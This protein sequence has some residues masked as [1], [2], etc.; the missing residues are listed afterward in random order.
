MSP[1]REKNALGGSGQGLP[2]SAFFSGQTEKKAW[3][4]GLGRIPS[5]LSV[6]GTLRAGSRAARHH[7]PQTRS[8]GTF[9][10]T[11]ARPYILMMHQ[12]RQTSGQASGHTSGHTSGPARKKA[13]RVPMRSGGGCGAGFLSENAVLPGAGLG[14]TDFGCL[15]SCAGA[16]PPRGHRGSRRAFCRGWRTGR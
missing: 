7:A 4:S 12:S 6:S 3:L 11:H 1:L 14:C 10:G 5:G 15:I 13:P 2:V 9:A 8:Q 16:A